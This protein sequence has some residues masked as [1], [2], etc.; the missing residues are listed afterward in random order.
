MRRWQRWAC[1][2]GALT[3]CVGG[4]AT[5][6][7]AAGA[8]TTKPGNAERSS[9][10]ASARRHEPVVGAHPHSRGR[11][12]HHLRA[13]SAPGAVLT[14]TGAANTAGPAS[15]LPAGPELRTLQAT[16]GTNGARGPPSVS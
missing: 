16:E 2:L 8:A 4:L 14:A 13:S 10:A 3:M 11:A 12:S 6:V 1:S 15:L 5:G 7:A 9:L